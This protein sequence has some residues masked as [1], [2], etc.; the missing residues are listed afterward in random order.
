MIGKKAT[1]NS[2]IGM[3][4][5]DK[6][7]NVLG[8]ITGVEQHKEVPFQRYTVLF[9]DG[10]KGEGF[11]VG[12]HIKILTFDEVEALGRDGTLRS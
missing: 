3:Y 1:R 10:T 8:Q 6:R 12:T 2:A 9:D 11:I 4:V 7:T 5:R